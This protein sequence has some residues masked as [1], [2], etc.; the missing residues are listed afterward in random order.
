VFSQILVCIPLIILYEISVFISRFIQRK[1]Q[2][3]D[4]V[5]AHK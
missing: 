3:A 4:I 1:Q 5:P 2:K